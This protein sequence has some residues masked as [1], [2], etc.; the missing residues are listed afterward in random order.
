MLKAEQQKLVDEVAKRVPGN[1]V[2]LH[3]VSF[4]HPTEGKV[5]GQANI[6][7]DDA[8]AQAKE[9]RIIVCHLVYPYSHGPYAVKAEKLTSE[10]SGYSSN[11]AARGVAESVGF[12]FWGQSPID[13]YKSME[14]LAHD[15][16]FEQNTDEDRVQVNDMFTIGIGDGYAVYVVTGIRGNK[17]SVEWRGIAND[18]YYDHHFG[19]GG[20]YSVANVLRYTKRNKAARRLFGTKGKNVNKTEAFETLLKEYEQNHGFPCP[21]SLLA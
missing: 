9:G 16:R 10:K 14:R 8:Y 20:N 7:D 18:D 3:H 2:V 17:C 1:T 13:D 5:F 12:M 4:D 11:H 6:F 15:I 19:G 21:V